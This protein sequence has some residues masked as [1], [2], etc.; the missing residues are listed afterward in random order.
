[1]SAVATILY[2]ALLTAVTILL[3]VLTLVVS[4]QVLGRYASFVPRAIWTEEISR[5][6]LEWM[7]FLGAA[8]AI[9][10]NEHFVID[11]IPGRFEE[12]FRKPIQ[13]TVLCFVAIA[14]LAIIV[15]GY[16]FALTGMGRTSTTSGLQLVWAFA[17]MPVSGIFMLIFV[18]ELAVRTLR[19]E[20]MTDF[21]NML[22]EETAVTPEGHPMPE[23]DE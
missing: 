7:V 12:R 11:V 10:R 18:F 3:G 19:G 20:S 9:R 8:I 16:N 1:M 6:C 14:A 5:L 4:Y 2:R 17:A 23:E 22:A 13:L 15:G 21:G